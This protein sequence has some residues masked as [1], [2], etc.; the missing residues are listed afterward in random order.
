MADPKDYQT[1]SEQVIEICSS[2]DFAQK[3]GKNGRQRAIE[4]FNKEKIIGEYLKC[5]QNVMD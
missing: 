4:Q 2:A 1:L 3:L 5:Y